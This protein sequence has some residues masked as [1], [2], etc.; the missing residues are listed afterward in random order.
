MRDYEF[1]ELDAAEDG[2]DRAWMRAIVNRRIRDAFH[3]DTEVYTEDVIDV[4]LDLRDEG[5]SVTDDQIDATI[6]GHL[7]YDPEARDLDGV[8]EQ[9]EVPA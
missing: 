9:T 4:L 7:A 8:D 5:E 6:R 2:G 1:D 3:P